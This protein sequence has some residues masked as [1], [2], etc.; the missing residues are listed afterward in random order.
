[1]MDRSSELW[2]EALNLLQDTRYKGP[3]T[4]L[5]NAVKHAESDT[6]LFC[7]LH[8]LTGL[9]AA[10][11]LD[12]TKVKRILQ[13]VEVAQPPQGYIQILHL[14][15]KGAFLQGVAKTDEA[16]RIFE[17][18][19]FDLGAFDNA[20]R[21]DVE[22]K[23]A[24]L[25]AFN[26]LWIWEHDQYREEKKKVQLMDQLR[27]ICTD[28]PDPEIRATYH[29]ILGA[30]QINPPFSINQLKQHISRGAHLLKDTQ[31]KQLIAI[32]L[33]IMRAQLFAGVVGVQAT[34][35]ARAAVAQSTASGNKL[36]QS[37]AQGMLAETFETDGKVAE[38][39]AARG[40]GIRLANEAAE[41]TREAFS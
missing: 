9:Q 41:R 1:M 35:S 36:W 17:S 23:V 11:L 7:Y 8:I 38:A 12:W 31:N 15:L 10:T 33:S 29:L 16:L 32:S 14:Y 26:R 30:A 27:P 18:P 3:I 37:V 13:I 22:S 25:A 28:H 39:R 2:Q 40:D 4:S 19:Q 5:S 20:K 34:K 21:G 6:E 24:I